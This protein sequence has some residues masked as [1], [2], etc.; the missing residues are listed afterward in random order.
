VTVFL[1]LAALGSALVMGILTAALPAQARIFRSSDIYPADYPTV[2]GVV[3]MDKLMRERSGGQHGITVLGHIDRDSESDTLAKLRAGTLDM[4][5]VNIAALETSGSPTLVPSLPFLFKSA[6]QMRRILDGPLGDEIL[7]G[8]DTQEVVG[9]CFY[10][11]GPRSFYS[12]KGPIK[13]AADLKGLKVRVQQS[14]GWTAAMRALGAEPVAMPF[15]A[16]F[17]GLQSGALEAADNNWPTYVASRHY[18]VAKYFSLTEHSMAPTVLVFSKRV[19]DQLSRDEQTLIRGA[20]R[21]S[22]GPMRKLW[23]DYEISGR[24][25]VET[26]GGAVVSDIDRKSFADALVP[27]Y[28]TIVTSDRLRAIVSRIQSE[29]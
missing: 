1:R 6:A 8:L 19:W 24:K 29:E 28:P 27:L 10:D 7:A 25:T 2:Q 26:A 4:A 15:E 21:D 9:L 12:T 5:R 16:V 17:S 18:N 22:V 14:A 3:Q 11:G 13:S 23:D 20:A